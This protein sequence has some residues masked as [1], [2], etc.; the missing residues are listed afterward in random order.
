MLNQRASSPISSLLRTS[1]RAVR[2]PWPW[3]MSLSSLVTVTKGRVI[4]AAT[5]RE[6]TPTTRN[7]AIPPKTLHKAKELIA[8]RVCT[9]ASW[10][11]SS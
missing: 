8:L 7:T 10:K 4:R 6:T 1:S 2:S 5:T 9:T 3:A 11:S